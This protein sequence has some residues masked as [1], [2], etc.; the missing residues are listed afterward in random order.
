MNAL[1][2]LSTYYHQTILA[3]PLTRIYDRFKGDL[4][5]GK[6]GELEAERF[7]LRKGYTIV[8][9]G[10]EDKTGEI[11]LIAVDNQ[12]IVFVEVKTRRSDA[13]GDPTEAVDDTKQLHMTKTSRSYLKWHRLT[14]QPARFD[15]IAIVWANDDSPP[16]IRHY[17]NAFE[18]V[19][20]F[21]FFN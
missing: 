21:Q 6:R 16:E 17:E 1:R 7:L 8:D 14:D 20:K 4:S 12:T 11:D 2:V 3:R 10:Y 13:A 5:F 19:G 18:P 9:R 15:V